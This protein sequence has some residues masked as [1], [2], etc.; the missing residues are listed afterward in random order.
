M[1]NYKQSQ[2]MV[3]ITP[4]GASNGQWW[5]AC[6]CAEDAARYLGWPPYFLTLLVRAGHIKPLGR[7]SQNSRKWYAKVELERLGCDAEWLDKAIRIV[8]KRVQAWNA[9]QRINEPSGVGVIDG[10]KK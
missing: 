8:E 3:H 5:P 6:L 1:T 9:K 7:P 2:Q 4:P 10:D